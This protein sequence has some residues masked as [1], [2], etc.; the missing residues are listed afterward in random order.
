[1]LHGPWKLDDK[2][3]TW[4]LVVLLPIALPLLAGVA[5]GIRQA[6]DAG[7]R[8]ERYPEMAA[9][10][11]ALRTHLTGLETRATIAHTVSQTEEI[12]LDELRE[13]QLT[14]TTTGH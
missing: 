14:A 6:L 7:R 4:P 12:L 11:T 1:M 10:L 3:I 13:W 9:R 5:S 8:K 2:P